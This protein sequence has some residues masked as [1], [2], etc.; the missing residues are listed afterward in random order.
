[1]V[2]GSILA[3]E[4]FYTGVL[5]CLYANSQAQLQHVLIPATQGM[6]SN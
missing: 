5:F 4:D 3:P 6:I 2:I 1:M